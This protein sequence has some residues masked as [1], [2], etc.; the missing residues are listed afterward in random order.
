MFSINFL[1]LNFIDFIFTYKNIFIAA[2]ALG[3]IGIFFGFFL[4][5]AFK[6]L[7]VKADEK[8]ALILSLLPGTNC[9]ACGFPGCQGLAEAIA[10]G[11]AEANGCVAGGAETTKKISQALGIDVSAKD[12]YVVF[13]HCRAGRKDAKVN[14]KYK[15]IHNCQAASLLFTG[16]KACIYGCIGLGSCVEVC[17]FDAIHINEDGVAVV[18]PDKC[19]FC[20][21]CIAVCPRQLIKEVPKKQKVLVICNNKDKG[22]KAKDVC[23][24]ACI[25][26]KICEKNC[27]TQAIVVKDNLAQID[28]TKC[29]HN[30]IC[31]EKCPQNCI[32]KFN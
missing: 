23:K 2:G 21:K 5:F 10:K 25:A 6:Y 14:Y 16:D 20:K 3:F 4:A 18:D 9:G 24:L 19:R 15:G 22:K 28:Y 1:S 29:N 12:E 13:V 32:V 8:E 11:K 27:P 17:P 30:A 7:A 31:V 26:C